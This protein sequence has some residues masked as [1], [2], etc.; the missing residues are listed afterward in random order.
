MMT[1]LIIHLSNL[2]SE[3]TMLT[4]ILMILQIMHQVVITHTS[5]S[6]K[7]KTMCL[8]AGKL[9]LTQAHVS[10]IHGL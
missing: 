5:L 2:K 3:V 4:R 10:S 9:Y 7:A 6:W 8:L 1:S